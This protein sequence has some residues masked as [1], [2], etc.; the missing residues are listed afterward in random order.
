MGKI[1]DDIFRTLCEKNPHLLIP[2]INEVFHQN[3]KMTDQI[4]LM[5]GEHHVMK[6]NQESLDQ[7]ITDS[8]IHIG[9]KIYHLECQSN[10]DGSMILRMVEYDFHIALENAM[11]TKFGY[12][13]KFPE[14]AVLYLRH[15]KNTP[16]EI[17]MKITFPQNV[18]VTYRVPVIK[19]QQYSGEDILEKGLS[20]LIPYCILKYEQIKQGE[21]L[22]EISTEYRKLHQGMI[23]ARDA[24][25]LN[26]YDISNIIDFTTRLTEH[27]F[28]ENLEAK[29]EV[30][31]VMGGEVL[32]T[33]ADQMIAKGR[34]EGIAEGLLEGQRKGL[35]EGERKGLLEGERRGLLEGER[36]GKVEIL[37]EMNFSIEKIAEKLNIS[38]EQVKNILHHNE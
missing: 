13:M 29:R 22:K 2:L 31:A 18:S 28:K 30:N 37:Y 10:P 34:E 26:E 19:V 6:D 12:E 38:A 11:P 3:Y 20:F 36:R 35:L 14:S 7:R 32:E 15:T 5:S 4:E 1:Y 33:Y 16:D 9:D 17:Q 24:G 21:S 8:T 23:K 25:I 27:L